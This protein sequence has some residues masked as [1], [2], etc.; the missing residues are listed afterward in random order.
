M[1]YQQAKDIRKKSFGTMLA[2]E[3]CGLFSS[4]SK[5]ISKR[6]QAKMTGLK[7]RFDPLNIAKFIT[8]GSNWAPAMLGKMFGVD[9]KRID[10]FS[11]VKQR[12][13]NTADKL[14]LVG[15]GDSNFIGILLNIEKLLHDGREEDK[16]QKERDSAFAEEKEYEKNRRHKELIEAITGKKYTGVP[17]KTATK[18]TETP[19]EDNDGSLNWLDWIKKLINPKWLAF[20][21]NPSFLAFA[22]LLAAIG[23]STWFLQK[24]ADNTNNMKALSPAEAENL[25][26]NG[27]AKDIEDAGGR[28]YLEDIIRNGKEKAKTVLAMPEGEEKQKALRDMGGENK[29]KAIAGDTKEY[30]VPANV[31]TGPE[32]VPPRPDTTGGKNAGRAKSWDNK[33]AKKYNPDGT[34]KTATPVENKPTSDAPVENKPTQADENPAAV[35]ST[36]KEIPPEVKTASEIPVENPPAAVA[37]NQAQKENINLNM[38]VSRP[39]PSTVVNNNV[40]SSSF[41][42]DSTRVPLPLVR[43]SEE[44]FQQMILYSTRVV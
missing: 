15:G 6:N 33:F 10:Y 29:V 40:N 30:T 35:P 18:L 4:L 31:D 41:S 5:T 23:I 13:K 42:D 16:L 38:P 44:T 25:L 19:E 1:D 36:S 11:G 27:Y 34:K 12:N 20:L 28:A 3:E 9:K 24:L 8:G 37:L 22:G 17:N 14:G 39:D 7:E 43:N 21:I 32:K 2:E 26:R